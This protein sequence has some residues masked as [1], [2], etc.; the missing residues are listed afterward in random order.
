MGAAGRCAELEYI[1]HD[2]HQSKFVLMLNGESFRF[3]SHHIVGEKCDTLEEAKENAA[4]CPTAGL[5]HHMW[6][7]KDERTVYIR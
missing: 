1:Q 3:L 4:G 2:D 6:L 7:M 5:A